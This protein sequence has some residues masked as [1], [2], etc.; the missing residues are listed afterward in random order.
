MESLKK[1]IHFVR[2]GVVSSPIG[3]VLKTNYEMWGTF[4]VISGRFKLHGT[5]GPEI[6]VLMPQF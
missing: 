1:V 5:G 3:V 6:S 2:Y 4:G